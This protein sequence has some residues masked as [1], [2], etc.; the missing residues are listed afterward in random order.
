MRATRQSFSA[1]KT[2]G[3]NENQS[4][5]QTNMTSIGSITKMLQQAQMANMTQTNQKSN[6]NKSLLENNKGLLQLKPA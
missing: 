6:Y 1:N 2:D 4:L 5:L 3:I